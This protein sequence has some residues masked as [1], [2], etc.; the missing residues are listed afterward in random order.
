MTVP[1]TALYAALGGVLVLALAW[2]VTRARQRFAV[3]L[4]TGDRPEVERAVRAHA[5]AV[6]Y[7]PVALVLLL[8]LELNGGR[9]WLLHGAGALLLVARVLH[10]VGLSG[11]G[12]PSFGRYWGT[13]GT[14][15]VI[16]GL[17][18]ANLLRL[19]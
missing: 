11:S 17:A 8:T 9:F 5:N 2:Q 1:V 18:V 7:L 4:G 15:L 3:G 6:E 14:W 16:L 10:A 12:G 19:L 13:A